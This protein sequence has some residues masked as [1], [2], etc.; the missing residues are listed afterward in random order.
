MAQPDGSGDRSL[1]SGS[2]STPEAERGAVRCGTP[3]VYRRCDRVSG[4]LILAMVVLTPWLFGTTQPWAIWLMNLGGFAL[5]LLLLAK[6]LIRARHGFCPARWGEAVPRHGEPSRFR[7]HTRAARCLIRSLAILTLLLLAYI[8]VSALNYRSR[9]ENG[10]QVFN[11]ASVAWLPFSYDASATWRLF[12]IYLGLAGFFWAT[13]DW[14]LGKTARESGEEEET[15]TQFVLAQRT[16]L[17]ERLS[18]VLWI[19]CL[20]GTLLGVVSIIQRLDGTE[21]LLWLIE[22]RHGTPAFHF[23]PFTYRG[24]G[25]QYFNLLWPVAL[26]FWWTLFRAGQTSDRVPVRIGDHPHWVLL[27]CVLILIACPVISLSH[28]GAV[29]TLCVAVGALGVFLAVNW[30]NSLRVRA[31]MLTPFV[32]AVGLVTYL[33]W[34]QYQQGLTNAFADDLGDRLEIYQN[35]QQIAVDHPLYGTGPGTFAAMYQLYRPTLDAAEAAYAHND[36][37]QTRITF[38]WIGLG[39]VL[40]MLAHVVARWWIRD[41]IE[42][43][44]DL[45][46]ILWLALA[47][48]LFHARF[49]FPLQVYSVLLLFLLLCSIACCVSRKG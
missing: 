17:P 38:G 20:N 32:L 48:C 18:R 36:W 33:G 47:G 5:G 35:A 14:L 26:A 24:N 10:V 37:L 31:A 22:P 39:I 7:P 15:F 34:N 29:V 19:L 16:G 25:A 41:G 49:D 27:P 4:F 8:L 11:E 2:G 43:R 23:G 12:W 28:G 1:P 40:A 3:S 6:R 9:F 21:K 42:T 46:A 44:W 30:R 13:R 45:V